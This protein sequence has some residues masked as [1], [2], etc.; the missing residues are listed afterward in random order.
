MLD[1]LRSPFFLLQS[2]SLLARGGLRE[3]I[4]RYS[5]ILVDFGRKSQ[6]FLRNSVQLAPVRSVV[7]WLARQRPHFW[8]PNRSALNKIWQMQSSVTQF[9]QHTESIT[10]GWILD[11][12][13]QFSANTRANIVA[14]AIEYRQAEKNTP[15]VRPRVSDLLCTTMGF[16]FRMCLVRTL[17]QIHLRCAI[18]FSVRKHQRITS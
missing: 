8:L 5:F 3:I 4:G 10:K 1:F 15:P 13:R 2:W 7:L 9:S 6:L 11:A 12:S 14:L 17:R 16:K 18:L